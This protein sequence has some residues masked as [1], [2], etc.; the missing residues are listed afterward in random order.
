MHG[1]QLEKELIVLLR[2]LI[3]FL[4]NPYKTLKFATDEAFMAGKQVIFKPVILQRR[5]LIKWPNKSGLS[6][7][8]IF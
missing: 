3:I 1:E 6:L 4:H 5:H 7:L 2:K 8:K